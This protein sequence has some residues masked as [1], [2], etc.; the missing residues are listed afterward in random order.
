MCVLLGRD[1][2]RHKRRKVLTPKGSI[3]DRPLLAA[4]GRVAAINR[5]PTSTRSFRPRAEQLPSLSA[6]IADVRLA[7]DGDVLPRRALL[8]AL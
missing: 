7:V 5:G 1:W 2:P 8:S 4:E 6:F 3:P